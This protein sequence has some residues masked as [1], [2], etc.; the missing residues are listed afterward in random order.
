MTSDYFHS[1]FCACGQVFVN[2][3][4]SDFAET[5]KHLIREALDVLVPALV[6]RFQAEVIFSSIVTFLIH[7]L[8]HNL[9]H[10]FSLALN[11][12]KFSVWENLSRS[13]Q[14]R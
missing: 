7:L 1:H 4:K 12:V 5:K 14:M 13:A 9:L 11:H 3:L 2:L 8:I 6:G 10:N